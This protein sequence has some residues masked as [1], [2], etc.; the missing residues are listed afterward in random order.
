MWAARRLRSDVVQQLLGQIL[1]TF[2]QIRRV[3]EEVHHGRIRFDAL[4]RDHGQS[5]ALVHA[6]ERAKGQHNPGF[7]GGHVDD[8]LA[9]NV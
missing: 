5:I 4:A 9:Q 1:P 8:S 2:E 7:R 6:S 3:A